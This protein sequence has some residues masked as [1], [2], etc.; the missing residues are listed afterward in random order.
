VNTHDPANNTHYYRWVYDETWQFN[1]K[2]R[3]D[4]ML[5]TNTNTIVQRTM[6]QDVYS[7]FGNDV[8]SNI[9][10]TS[11]AKLS[12]DVVYQSPLTSIP[13]SSEKFETRYS[14]LVKQYALTPDA[15]TFYQNI[16][17]NT[18]QLGSI[19]DAQ[20]SQISGNIHNVANA[21]E[22]VIGFVSITNVQTKRIFIPGSIVPLNIYTIYP[23]NCAADTALYKDKGGLN[24]VA[25]S[26]IDRP[27]TDLPLEPI[28]AGSIIIGYT[29]SSLE[30]ADCTLR[31]TTVTP[32]FWK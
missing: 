28:F 23:Y 2:Y 20:P 19:F 21:S 14:I 13:L 29:Y 11:T 31:G 27:I 25:N 17:T 10:L 16:K 12:K 15:Y 7:C 32:S 22:P 18:E 8:S 26:L 4:Y 9:L 30:C 24:D 5:D 3:S 1:A 6:A